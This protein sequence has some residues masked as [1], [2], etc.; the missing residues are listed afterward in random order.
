PSGRHVCP[1]SRRQFARRSEPRRGLVL[2]LVMVTI[3]LLTL[4]AYT[5]SDLMVAEHQAAF[6]AG[7]QYQARELA[8]SGAELLR[9]LLSQ[10]PAARLESGGLFHNPEQLQGVI[11]LDDPEAEWRGR[12]TVLAPSPGPRGFYEGV[13]VGIENTS[14]CIN[15]RT[16]MEH[17]DLNEIQQRQMLMRLP[18]MTEPIADAIL[19]WMDSDDVPRQYGAESTYYASLNPPYTPKNGPLESI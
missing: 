4:A 6:I 9:V 14:A 15:L 13:R 5:F 17:P 10:S 7:Q 11:V 12:V 3:A 19:D 16:L 8:R 1:P 18:G 2:I